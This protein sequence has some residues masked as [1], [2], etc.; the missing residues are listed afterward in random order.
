MQV[1]YNYL[2]K[3]FEHVDDYFADLRGLVKSGEFTLGPYVE[4]F[5]KKFGEYIGVKH[6]ISVNNGTDA[7]ILALK[8][9]GV[10]PGD[11]VIS[12]P[13][14]FYATI[15]AIVAVG[16]RPVFVD[17]DDRYQIDADKIQKA[18]TKKTRAIL[19]VHWAG[20]PADMKEILA[21]AKKRRL[22]VIED[23]CPSV[24]AAIHGKKCGSFGTVNAFSM[25][26][27]KP[28][29]VWGDGGM[30]VTDDDKIAGFLRMY[31]NHGMTDR[32]HIDIWGVNCRLQPVQAIVGI[33]V[34]DTIEDLVE[35][36]NRNARQLDKGLADLKEFVSTPRRPKGYREAYQLYLACFKRRDELFRC[37]VA[38]GVEVKV[39]YPVP[40]PLQKA[41]K[42]LGYK[43]GD[44]PA[45]EKQANE[46]MTLP[47][48][49]FITP[50]Q[51]DY[52]LDCIHK[53]Y[54]R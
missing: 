48:H 14:T 16:A 52:T 9:A 36:R 5:E 51:I 46:V 20:C 26:P 13:N 7:L 43:K 34:L 44:F 47:S 2:D 19:P 30:T 41:A 45:A 35:A 32:D 24:G 18:I 33:R 28:L 22:P 50:E 53:F 10:K 39:H 38:K 15:G 23:A 17:S 6:V 12:V 11:E 42:S 54:R 25:H 8:G 40:L 4:K 1:K 27:L 21:V 49:Q 3:Q 37:L 31:R 29:N